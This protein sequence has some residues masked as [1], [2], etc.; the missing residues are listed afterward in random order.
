[1]PWPCDASSAPPFE[2][3]GFDIER[4]RVDT[5]GDFEPIDDKDART[6]AF[7]SR[8]A[9]ADPPPLGAGADL[10]LAFP[11]NAPPAPPVAAHMSLDDVLVKA[12][13]SGPPPGSLHQYRI[14]SLDALGRR[15]ATALDGS[16]V[17]LEKR[18]PPPQPV[19]PPRDPGA[20]VPAGVRARVLQ[21]LDPDLPAADRTLLGASRDAVVLEWGWTQ[22]ERDR[23]PHATEFR[24]YWQPL[25]PDV[26]EGAVTGP[27]TL[28]GSLFEL[29][30][31][32]DRPLAQDAM[33]GRYVSLPDYP[34]RI[35]SHTAGQSIVLRV[36]RSVLEP[37]R[38]PGAAPF[39]FR[40]ALDGSEQR[41]PAWAERSAVVPIT[42]AESYRHVFRDR[43]TLEAQHP[44]SR[45][46]AG[47]SAADAQVYVDDVLPPAAA[48][49]RPARQR[50]RDRDVRCHRA[51]SSGVPVH[52]AAAA[53][54]RARDRRRRARRR[55]AYSRSSTCPRYCPRS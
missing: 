46:W 54:G 5:N 40:P 36:E 55:R 1:M 25:A 20:V 7:G 45:V 24:V 4:R 27:P 21:A 38:T 10:E 37:Q 31:T 47:V 6:L 15:S 44:R 33:V 18:R 28:A 17:R 51:V 52:R 43:L 30:A 50:E 35:A 48:E 12:D 19:G 22:A 32:L 29:S 41:P 9:A 16:I 14:F 8:G 42:A 13:G 23:D 3:L 26:V 39:A 49:R 11:E 34:F 53:A 2:A